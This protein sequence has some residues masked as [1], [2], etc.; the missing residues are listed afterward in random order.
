MAKCDEGYL[1]QV[2]GQDVASLVE[3]D[4]YLRFVIGM[5]D[6]ELLHTLGERH[7]R[8]NPALAQFIAHGDFAPIE[9]EGDFDK[10]K[11]DAQLVSQRERL[12]TR[13]WLRLR[14][15]ASWNHEAP[16]TDYLLPEFADKWR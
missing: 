16:I 6:P 4:L 9:V 12:V 11:L 5:V 13:G 8:C 1:C 7:I 10:R 2:C 3:S 15:A 14:E